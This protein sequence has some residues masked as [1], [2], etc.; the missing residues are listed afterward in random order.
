MSSATP[1]GSSM[2]MVHE[3]WDHLRA[4][5]PLAAWA[6]WRRALRLEGGSP[7]AAQALERL[8]KS[9]DLP[10]AARAVYRLRAPTD[11]TRRAAWDERLRA[12]VG[13]LT[14]LGDLSGNGRGGSVDTDLAAMAEAFSQLAAEV[15]DDAAAWY[16]TALCWAWL[17]QNCEA[18]MSLRSEV[19]HEAHPAPDGAIKAWTLAEVL[20]A[21]GG[22]EEFADDLRFA[23]TIPWDPADTPEL[24]RE[25]PEIQQVPTPQAPGTGLD[26]AEAVEVFEWLDRPMATIDEAGADRVA[27]AAGLPIVLASVMVDPASRVLRLSSPRADALQQAEER[28]L[29][30]LGIDATG[31]PIGAS[32]GRAARA[33]SIRREAE[34]LPLPFLDADVWTVRMPAGLDV[35]LADDLRREWVEHYYEDLWIHR[36][37]HGLDDRTP[38]ATAAA[39]HRGN[40]EAR[41]K[42][43]AVVDFREQLG[44]RPVAIRL[45]HGYPFDRL[46]RR[47]GLPANEPDAVDPADLSCASAW[48]LAALDPAALDDQRLRDAVASAAG[49]RDDA[50]TAPPAIELLRRPIPIP[51]VSLVDAVSPLV[52]R[53]M[54]VG[55]ADA[56]LDRIDQ[57]RPLAD[58][59]TAEIIDV[60][61]A[62]ILARASRPDEAV[63]VYRALIGS[64]AKGAVMALDGAETLID[65]RH[66][67]EARPLLH[68]ALDLSQANGLRWTARR[69][70]ALLDGLD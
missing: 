5:R 45:Y 1:G 22:A 6:S 10:A 49:I 48:E 40:A 39:A 66:F 67:D 58:P 28:L 16:N 51:G 64:D 55:N 31:R 19:S 57:A 24:L 61:R 38:L 12:A 26:P 23:C 13:G 9:G 18:I 33:G 50:I 11:A 36:V 2:A 29:S 62:E 70:Q 8:E 21:G 44:R 27:T 59:Q 63:R 20:R 14:H 7:A 52:R 35:S 65:N 25:F 15:P 47:L 68:T 30:R 54:G 42:L 60:W 32:R 4:R 69:A 53:A 43:A 56:A 17:G 41:A 37:R 3:G 34:P 46:R